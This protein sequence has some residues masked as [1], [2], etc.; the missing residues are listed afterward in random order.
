MVLLGVWLIIYIPL[1]LSL[2]HIFNMDEFDKYRAGQMPALK[3]LMQMTTL[4]FRRAH[5]PAFSHLPV[6]YTHLI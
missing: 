1:W 2:I 6:S 5:R 3:N 4:T